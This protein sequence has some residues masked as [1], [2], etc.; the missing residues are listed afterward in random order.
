MSSHKQAIERA[1]G[2][3]HPFG[4]EIRSAVS[5]IFRSSLSLSM[6]MEEHEEDQTDDSTTIICKVD[7]CNLENVPCLE[8][9]NATEPDASERIVIYTLVIHTD[10]KGG[11]LKFKRSIT[12][13][14]EYRVSCPKDA[15]TVFV[16]L[17]SNLV[18][19]DNHLT[20]Q[21]EESVIDKDNESQEKK[22]ETPFTKAKGAGGL[23]TEKRKQDPTAQIKAREEMVSHVAD[24]RIKKGSNQKDNVCSQVP[25]PPTKVP[26]VTPS[27]HMR[28][29]SQRSN[30]TLEKGSA[31]NQSLILNSSHSNTGSSWQEKATGINMISAGQNQ[32][33]RTD[34]TP[35]FTNNSQTTLQPERK[36]PRSFPRSNWKEQ[37]R[38]Q[39]SLQAGAYGTSPK[40]TNPFSAFKYDPNNIESNL[41][42]ISAQYNEQITKQSII[43][44]D[45]ILAGIKVGLS[46]S[47]G[48]G[49]FNSNAFC[50]RSR[51]KSNAHKLDSRQLLGLK[52]AEQNAYRDQITPPPQTIHE[53]SQHVT[54]FSREI[55]A[56]FQVQKGIPLVSRTRPGIRIY[57]QRIPQQTEHQV[58]YRPQTCSHPI[59]HIQ[60]SS[61]MCQPRAAVGQSYMPTQS[62]VSCYPKDV[63]YHHSLRNFPQQKEEPSLVD[64]QR[65]YQLPNSFYEHKQQ[66]N[67]S[68]G[69]NFYQE[70]LPVI[71]CR[72][73][74]HQPLDMHQDIS[75]LHHA[76]RPDLHSNDIRYSVG[77]PIAETRHFDSYIQ[78]THLSADQNT[79]HQQPGYRKHIVTANRDLSQ[80][81]AQPSSREPVQEPMF[82]PQ[83]QN[84][85][86]DHSQF[87][88][89]RIR[90]SCNNAPVFSQ[91][92]QFHPE[93]S[94]F[95]ENNRN[96]Y[97]TENHARYQ[98]S[99]FD[100]CDMNATQGRYN[101]HTEVQTGQHQQEMGLDEYE[102]QFSAIEAEHSEANQLVENLLD[103]AFF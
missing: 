40:N 94:M 61:R 9:A 101:T 92:T 88:V 82:Q 28:E 34:I 57:D 31:H 95:P 59:M 13:P 98:L 44:R 25:K 4:S 89:D 20:I 74:M 39:L 52:V 17:V 12:G 10:Q 38:E 80:F 18:G 26:A 69:S 14:D 93:W 77:I 21:C 22:L 11:L 51:R 96:D 75:Y 85:N 16:R 45:A 19:L 5:K 78:P 76:N 97:A 1:A 58:L 87:S 43:P 70:E 29:N 62:Q 37:K 48:R 67:Y 56:S 53:Q 8:E 41:D 23:I 65:N 32:G 83:T 102:K 54:P 35:N 103:E 49:K 100:S 84:L 72:T 33:L 3:L 79:P 68:D 6:C 71:A 73:S 2:R 36:R 91:H 90:E 81:S 15:S 55:G 86:A 46:C 64:I 50:S 7:K 47:I 99:Q 42:S 30:F 60:N 66:E 27:P 24:L 63:H